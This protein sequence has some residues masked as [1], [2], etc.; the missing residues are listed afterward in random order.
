MTV[1]LRVTE[2][3]HRRRM[4]PKRSKRG[5]IAEDATPKLASKADPRGDALQAI[6]VEKGMNA[7]SSGHGNLALSTS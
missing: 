4:R 1:N 3:Q 2:C 7:I 5:P 6:L